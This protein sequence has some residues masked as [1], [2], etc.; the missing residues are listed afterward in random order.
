MG[1]LLYRVRQFLA[2]VRAGPLDPAGLEL[3]QT[4]LPPQGVK[5]FLSMPRGD[6][7][8]SLTILRGLLAEGNT[9]QPLLQAALVHDVAKSRVLIRRHQGP[10]PPGFPS[11]MDQ[12]KQMLDEWQHALKMLDDQN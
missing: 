9:A 2:A 5:L 7:Q 12:E 8:H 11:R 10:L 3:V 6:Q 1:G 4:H